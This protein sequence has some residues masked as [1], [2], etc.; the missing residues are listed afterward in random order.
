MGLLDQVLGSA[1]GSNDGRQQQGGSSPLIGALMALLSSGV[2]GG[3][4]GSGGGLGGLLGGL[5]GGSSGGGLG[6]GLGGLLEQFQQNGHGEAMN[7]WIGSGD[8]RPIAP[9]HLDQALGPN[10]VDELSTQTGMPRDEVLSELSRVLP[11]V[12][13]KMTP[14]G[15]LPTEAEAAHW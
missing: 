4:R 11:G 13:D 7:S 10:T 15:R 12:V 3:G 8:N 14:H 5:T 9:H 2:L 1:F 6:G